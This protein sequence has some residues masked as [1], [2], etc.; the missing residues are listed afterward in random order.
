MDSP[1]VSDSRLAEPEM[2]SQI[3]NERA[4]SPNV[5]PEG[6]RPLIATPIEKNWEF[7]KD[8]NSNTRF[9]PVSQFPT[10]IHLDLMHHGIIT[11]P[12]IAT[13]EETVQWVGLES[14]VY[15]TTFKCPNLTRLEKALLSF[16][17][18]DTFA[19][20]K[21]NGSQILST[22]NMFLP[23]KV[24]ITDRVFTGDADNEL[25]IF[26]KSAFQQGKEIQEEHPQHKWGCWNGDPSRCA[27][28]KAQYHYGWDWGPCLITCGPWKPIYLEI[29]TA[30]ISDLHVHSTVDESLRHA[31]V[32]VD[33]DVDGNWETVVIQLL[34]DGVLEAEE[35][36]NISFNPALAT[37]HIENPELWYPIHYG[38]Q[39]M[40]TVVATLYGGGSKL[41]SCT[42]RIG[43]RRAQVI[44]RP[45]SDK[46]SSG[47]TFFFEINNTPIFCGGSNWIPAD[48]FLPRISSE[49]YRAW[50][51]LI[52]GGNQNMVRVWGGGIYEADI[53]Y[54][55]CDE[56]GLLVWQDFMFACGNYPAHLSFLKN[57]EREAIANVKRLRHHP[58]IIIWAGNNE[59]YQYAES[60][61][62]GYDPS[63]QNRE[64]WLGSTFPARYIYEELLVNVMHKHAPGTYYHF[65]SP[66]GGENSRDSQNG[67]IH[68]WNV[69]HGTQE[70]YQNF[71][72]LS[73]RFVSEFGMQAF[74]NIKTIDSYL[75]HQE[76]DVDRYAQSKTI[77]F[78]NKAAGHERRLATY[79]VENFRYRFE[80]L[81]KYINYTQAMQAD[82]LATAYRLWRREWKGPGQEYCAGA[83]VWQ[84]NDSWPGTSW[85]VVDYYSRPK[86]AYYAVKR[87]LRPV[88]I[89]VKRSVPA[90]SPGELPSGKW[91]RIIDIWASNFELNTKEVQV[92]VKV[93]DVLTGKKILSSI[94][95]NHLVL[96]QN[97]T[98][99]ITQFDLRTVVPDTCDDELRL[100]VAVYLLENEKIIARHINW[101]EPVKYVQ[102]QAAKVDMKLCGDHDQIELRTDLPVKG[103]TLSSV[104]KEVVFEDNYVDL[105]PE[106][107]VY[108]GVCGVKEGE[109]CLVKHFMLN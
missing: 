92:V 3:Q 59:D 30:R 58:S 48:S 68:Q 89:G 62:L 61:N 100:V 15:R 38:K 12:F 7:K 27:V 29:F 21:L 4:V 10:N 14:W 43:L 6:P 44:Q 39:R 96:Q 2:R 107:P 75:L 5:V 17:G 83:L 53:F 23:L 47:K 34:L 78:H 66:W 74:P 104:D 79:L 88:I 98:V 76:H 18:L 51:N 85:A 80:P 86:H 82:C 95:L 91:T 37:F 24:D 60:E 106:D 22:E 73:G 103:L 55:L 8:N 13:N 97:R 16:E 72:K 87:E 56:L 1:N 70:K 45:L 108:I 9:R 32:K 20:I 42:K 84:M 77:D 93:F 94:I 102:L 26:F 31:Q 33:V 36:R 52:A 81:E 19:T 65:G 50:L 69:W 109:D 46:H 28:R 54:E 25:Q 101:P 63:D 99:E 41:D 105:V 67:D 90:P 40:Y 71:D 49:K 35:T 57:V 64:N 11:D